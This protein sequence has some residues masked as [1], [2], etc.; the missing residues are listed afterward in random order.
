MS[1]NERGDGMNALKKSWIKNGSLQGFIAG[2]VIDRLLNLSQNTKP[3]TDTNQNSFA[4]RADPKGKGMVDEHIWLSSF[5]RA[6][7]KI[8]TMP[9]EEQWMDPDGNPFT[10][11]TVNKRGSAIMRLIREN[12]SLA[13]REQIILAVSLAE[14]PVTEHV[15]TGQTDKNGNPIIKENTTTINENGIFT[16]MSW[17]TMTDDEVRSDIDSLVFASAKTQNV[18]RQ[19]IREINRA[20]DIFVDIVEDKEKK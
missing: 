18:K 15:P 11:A 6:K 19:A 14:K 2:V 12:Y 9:K 20:I 13:D 17:F 10:R 7:T 8:L 5:A 1:E 16:I 4:L 3:N